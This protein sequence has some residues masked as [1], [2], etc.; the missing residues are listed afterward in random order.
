MS[1]LK[2]FFFNFLTIF[3]ANHLLPGIDVVMQVKLPHVGGD[4][5]FA[6]VLGGLNALIYPTLKLV[7]KRSAKLMLTTQIALIAIVF[8]FGAYAILKL[9]SI[10]IMISSLEGYFIPAIVVTIVS[11]LTNFLAMK[12]YQRHHH[13]AESHREPPTTSL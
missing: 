5:L 13:T 12:A 9:L 4:L 7:M 6:I 8:N 10:G 2:S 11:F 3:F 1:Y